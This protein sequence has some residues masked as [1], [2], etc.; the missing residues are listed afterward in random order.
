MQQENN[1]VKLNHEQLRAGY[2][3]LTQA[4]YGWGYELADSEA[5]GAAYTALFDQDIANGQYPQMA[6]E[7]ALTLLGI[8]ESEGAA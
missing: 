2:D 1:L 4:W 7:G 5:L 3:N 6:A 8:W